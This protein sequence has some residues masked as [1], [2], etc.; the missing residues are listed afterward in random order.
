MRALFSHQIYFCF[1]IMVKMGN[2][3]NLYVLTF[4]NKQ[5]PIFQR[6]FLIDNYFL[7]PSKVT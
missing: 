4:S 1:K 6:T 3:M 5:V 2:Y 7:I